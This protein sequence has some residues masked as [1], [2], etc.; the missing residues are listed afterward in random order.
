VSPDVPT[1]GDQFNEP[2]AEVALGQFGRASRHETVG[3]GQV[4]LRLAL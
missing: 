2:V 1:H 4:G 3:L